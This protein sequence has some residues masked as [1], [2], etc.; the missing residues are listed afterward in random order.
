[1]VPDSLTTFTT[2][3]DGPVD[4]EIGPNDGDVYYLA[5]NAGEVRHIRFVGDNR[6]PVAVAAAT[7]SAGLAPLTVNFSSAGSNDP[8]A[9]PGDHLR[10]GLRRW[11]ART[12]RDPNPTHQYAANGVYTATLTVTDPFF[13]TGSEALTDHRRQHAADAGDHIARR[14]LAL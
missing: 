2:S 4:I 3:G 14:R 12:R 7:P 13:A 5:I 9:E 8:D 10:L 6:P 1:M 11:H